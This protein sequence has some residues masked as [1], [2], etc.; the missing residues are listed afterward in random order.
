M[1]QATVGPPWLR[2][3][4]AT[5]ACVMGFLS[6][7]NSAPTRD[8]AF[9]VVRPQ[10]QAPGRPTSGAI[11]QAGYGLVLFEDTRAR[12]VGDILSIRLNESTDAS[13]SAGTTLD[14]TNNTSITNPTLFGTSPRFGLPGA[15]PLAARKDLNLQSSLV[16][17]N[18]FD[19]DAQ[20]KQSN[21]L[22]GDIAVTVAEVL[23]NGNLVVQ[24]EKILTLNQGHEQIRI[25]GI[26]RVEDIAPDNTI[27]STRVAN[28]RIIYAGE[29]VVADAN[30]IGWLGRFFI[31]ALFPF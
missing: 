17:S 9:A 6:G 26:V 12:R 24:G 30:V 8:P 18:A 27:D 28:A 21:K 14:K 16:S 3:L 25:S 31:S 11:Y 29:G 20:S 2:C 5:L 22:T 19:G 7:C 4:G 1:N 13:K 23:P 15:L 10:M